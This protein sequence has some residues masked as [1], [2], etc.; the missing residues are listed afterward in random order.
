MNLPVHVQ[1]WLSAKT[2]EGR[3]RLLARGTRPIGFDL[4]PWGDRGWRGL[5]TLVVMGEGGDNEVFEVPP[6]LLA[7][8]VRGTK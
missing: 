6:E 1:R 7:R 2:E 4:R 3:A 5:R 8:P